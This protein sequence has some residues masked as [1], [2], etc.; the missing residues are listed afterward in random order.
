M[1][2]LWRIAR[3][4]GSLVG[5]VTLAVGIGGT[6]DDL[7]KWLEWMAVLGDL[8]AFEPW[9]A[10]LVIAGGGLIIALNIPRGAYSSLRRKGRVVLPQVVG[11]PAA[12]NVLRMGLEKVGVTSRFAFTS[13]I[14]LVSIWVMLLVI[15]YL[16]GSWAGVLRAVAITLIV[17]GMG[18]ALGKLA[19]WIG[20]R[21]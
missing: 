2:L 8:L 14:M 19:N 5:L 6:S 17:Y 1:A 11:N 21:D 20:L 3:V 13:G 12:R 4:I 10:G 18:F 9:R 15:T 7:S 16:F